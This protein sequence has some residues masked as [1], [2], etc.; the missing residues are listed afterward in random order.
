MTIYF[1]NIIIS[2]NYLKNLKK[3]NKLN[4]NLKKCLI[5]NIKMEIK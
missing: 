3:Y 4:Y 1:I 5:L 2:M